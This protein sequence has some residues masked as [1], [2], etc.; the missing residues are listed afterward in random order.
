MTIRVGNWNL[1]EF[2]RIRNCEGMHN[3][4]DGI[5][6]VTVERS[7]R[8]LNAA[9]A[10]R[11]QPVEDGY[12]YN[13]VEDVGDRARLFITAYTARAMAHEAVNHTILK[14]LPIG[15]TPP[16]PAPNPEVA[17]ELGRKGAAARNRQ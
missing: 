1:D 16:S 9:Q 7:N 12:D 2:A 14:S 11:H 15:R 5:G 13:V 8:D 17:R 3:A 6:R 4:L 10:H